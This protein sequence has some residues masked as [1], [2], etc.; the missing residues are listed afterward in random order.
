MEAPVATFF[1]GHVGTGCMGVTAR[2]TA[3]KRSCIAAFNFDALCFNWPHCGARA[4][5]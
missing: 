4:C 3:W 1:G 5:T 2:L